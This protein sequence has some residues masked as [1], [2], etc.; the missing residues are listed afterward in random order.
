MWQ[1][2]AGSMRRPA[3]AGWLPAR[4]AVLAVEWRVGDLASAGKFVPVLLL[5]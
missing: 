2:G 4:R 5:R 3:K 1:T